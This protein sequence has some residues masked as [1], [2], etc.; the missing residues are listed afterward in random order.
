[1][2][3]L[4][5]DFVKLVLIAALLALPVAYFGTKNWLEAYAYKIKPDWTMFMI[6]IGSVLIIAA[7][8]ISFHIMK[9]AL[10]NPAE[11]IRYE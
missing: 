10:T 4:S 3:I 8:T 11:T 7:L 9:T 1:M 6:P 5:Y 2:T